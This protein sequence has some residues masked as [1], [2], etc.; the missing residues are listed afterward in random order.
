MEGREGL[1]TLTAS[2]N[3]AKVPVILS[4][5]GAGSDRTLAD[6]WTYIWST[7]AIVGATIWEWQAQGMYDK[8][9]ERWNIPSPGARND[10]KTG[11]RTSGGNGPVTADRQ[12]API[13][14]NLKMAHSPVNTT[15]REIVP[16]A[17]QCV[18]PLQN[19][20]SF[21]DLAELT[22]RWQALAGEKVLAS[23]ESHIAAKPR[24]S[25]DASFPATAGMDTLRLEFFHPDGR[26]VYVTRLHTK[27][28]QG[29]AAPAALAAAGPVRLSETDQSVVVQ[30]AG[31]QLVLDKHTAQITSW[32]AGD[33]DIVLGG[34]ILNL[35][36]SS[37]GGRRGGGAGGVGGS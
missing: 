26:S 28:Y 19:R 24:S 21:T 22:C 36:E 10:P 6:N 3:R 35:G 14:W 17:G 33:Q 20:Y 11:Y 5:Y 27:S 2:P 18:V 12:I 1:K 31:T 9:P 8:F 15:A 29:P 25:V 7:D 16:A 37:G 13:Y 34:P 30:A 4:E 23:G 32:R